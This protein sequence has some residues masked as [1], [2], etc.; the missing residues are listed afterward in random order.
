MTKKWY[1]VA[2]IVVAVA[3]L[4][5]PGKMIFDKEKI[6][7]SG[8]EFKFQVAPIDPSDP[9][10]G[11]YILLNFLKNHVEVDNYYDLKDDQPVYILLEVDEK[12]FAN[13]VGISVDAPEG[14][15]FIEA[16]ISYH[17]RS[18]VYFDYPFDRFYMDEFKA[19][20]A[21]TLYQQTLRDTSAVVYASVFIT[22]G[23]PVLND[24]LVNGVS[25]SKLV[26]PKK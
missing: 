8:K 18:T 1:I 19:Q 26:T 3:Q 4:A 10:R 25:I 2:F 21:E 22:Q 14:K 5:V 15:D 24:V 23:R 17:N 13:P 7:G 11:K 12:G 20:G 9:F 6:L 16:K